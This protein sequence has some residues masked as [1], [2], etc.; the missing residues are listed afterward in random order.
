MAVAESHAAYAMS[1]KGKQVEDHGRGND[2]YDEVAHGMAA[3]VLLHPAHNACGGIESEGRA[4]GEH[5]RVNAIGEARGRKRV[6][7]A[8]AGGATDDAVPTAPRAPFVADHGHSSPALGV[9]RVT[10]HEAE[11]AE[12]D[13][14]HPVAGAVV[15]ALLAQRRQSVMPF[16][17]QTWQMKV[18]HP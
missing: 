10:D 17:L 18:P 4:P 14:L 6:E 9:G 12:V 16:M 11:W 7:L 15:D 2:R 13:A 3:L 1:T 8:R 5:D